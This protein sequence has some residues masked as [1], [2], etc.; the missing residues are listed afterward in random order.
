MYRLDSPFSSQVLFLN[1]NNSQTRM[2]DGEGSNFF[3]FNSPIQCPLNCNMLFSITDAQFP[4]IM[5]L[6]NETNNKIVFYVPIFDRIVNVTIQ[7]C[8]GVDVFLRQINKEIKLQANGLFQLYGEYKN[9][10]ITWKS[11]YPFNILNQPNFETTCLE[12]IGCKRNS[13]GDFENESPGILKSS[14]ANPAYNIVMDS[15]VNFTGTRFIFV[16]FK[17]ITVNNMNS[18]GQL[19]NAVVR[20]D[21]NAQPGEMIFYRPL[22]VHKFLIAKRSIQNLNFTLTDVNDRPL[23]L[24]S[25]NAQITVKID[26]IYIP[27]QREVDEGTIGYAIRQLGKIPEVN[28]E[29]RGVY[30]PVTNTF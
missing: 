1:S 9:F 25:G 11:N 30:N 19:D 2:I 8:Y 13:F 24:F 6:I 17:N 29:S 26:F 16:K 5:Q 14:Q 21:N 20:I 27:Q 15:P 12:L 7:E 3:S 4:N 18:T 28:T 10:R 22:E 23:N